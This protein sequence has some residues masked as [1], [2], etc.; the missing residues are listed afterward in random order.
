MHRA[1]TDGLEFMCLLLWLS[2]QTKSKS[3]CSFVVRFL[4]CIRLIESSSLLVRI[5]FLQQLTENICSSLS[6]PQTNLINKARRND[7]QV[8]MVTI[9]CVCLRPCSQSTV[10]NRL[11]PF[12]SLI[13]EKAR[14]NNI[15]ID[16]NLCITSRRRDR[17][18]YIRRSKR[19]AANI[20]SAQH[21]QVS[22]WL[23]DRQG[24]DDDLV[25][26]I[27]PREQFFL[28]FDRYRASLFGT[29]VSPIVNG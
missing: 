10:T 13:V 14:V 22:S 26:A 6:F 27:D 21:V 2:K 24:E 3:N 4:F 20:D 25:S 9:K 18:V 28:S 5:S 11:D 7:W 29:T 1:S 16:Y 17:D 15:V 19:R 12:G 8:C 23:Y